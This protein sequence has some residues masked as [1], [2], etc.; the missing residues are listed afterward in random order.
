MQALHRTKIQH[1]DK[2]MIKAA[3]IVA[4]NAVGRRTIAIMTK[5]HR[6]RDG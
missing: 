3:M 1:G 6:P 2:R 4:I 5:R